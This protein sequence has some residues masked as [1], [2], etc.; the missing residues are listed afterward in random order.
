MRIR[1][2]MKTVNINRQVNGKKLEQVGKFCLLG[3][4]ITNDAKCPV[5]MRR[6]Y[7]SNGKRCL[8]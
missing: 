3:N 7:N 5:E 1:K 8:V 2:R 6:I 4:V